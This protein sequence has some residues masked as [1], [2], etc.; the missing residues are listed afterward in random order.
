MSFV[1]P[2]RISESE[3]VDTYPSKELHMK[4]Y[5]AFVI[6]VSY[7]QAPNIAIVVILVTKTRKRKDAELRLIL[8]PLNFPELSPVV[9]S[10]RLRKKT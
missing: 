1:L 6:N 2:V 10:R 3:T 5:S 7:L 9:K 8:R 4:T